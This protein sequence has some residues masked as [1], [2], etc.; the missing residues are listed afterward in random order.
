MHPLTPG[1]AAEPCLSE[2]DSG[3]GANPLILVKVAGGRRSHGDS[4]RACPRVQPRHKHHAERETLPISRGDALVPWL[5]SQIFKCK[6]SCRVK[7]LKRLV[8]SPVC[9]TQC[10]TAGGMHGVLVLP[11]SALCGD[12]PGGM[13]S[14]ACGLGT[15]AVPRP[16]PAFQQLYL[17][18]RLYHQQPRGL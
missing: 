9:H 14:S 13:M 5:V 18:H 3:F 4:L 16:L 1:R 6:I 12:P 8:Q 7:I 15:D 10:H 11:G 17:V 2:C